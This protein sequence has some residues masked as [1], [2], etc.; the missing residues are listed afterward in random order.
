MEYRLVSIGEKAVLQAKKIQFELNRISF[1][2][3]L[4]RFYVS[5]LTNTT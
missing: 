3:Y 2:Y 1:I 5:Y 4:N